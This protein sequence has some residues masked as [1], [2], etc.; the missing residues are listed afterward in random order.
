MPGELT[1]AYRAPAGGL[2]F[3]KLPKSGKC[4][5]NGKIKAHEAIP[6]YENT[7]TVPD[8]ADPPGDPIPPYAYPYPHPTPSCAPDAD[9][10]GE[11]G[12][13]LCG[14][15]GGPPLVNTYAATEDT[16][17]LSVCRK[18]GWKGVEAYKV[19]HGR[20]AYDV[21]GLRSAD[22]FVIVDDVISWLC[23]G[24]F[25]AQETKYLTATVSCTLNRPLED[26]IITGSGSI[27]VNRDSGIVTR[28][29]SRTVPEGEYPWDDLVSAA[30]AWDTIFTWFQAEL[31]EAM[32]LLPPEDLTF[33]GGG[34]AGIWSWENGDGVYLEL[35]FAVATG[36]F[37]RR[38]WVFN[39][40]EGLKLVNREEYAVAG[41][42][43]VLSSERWTSLGLIHV[44]AEE[45]ELEC[46]LSNPYMASENMTEAI[47]LAAMWNLSDDAEHPWR[48]DSMLGLVP[49]VVRNEPGSIAP[50]WTVEM[51]EE[52]W[53]D[54]NTNTYDGQVMG[55]P[56]PA[57]YERHWASHMVNWRGC[58]PSGE[59][60]AWYWPSYGALSPGNLPTNATW[61]T[62]P[63]E[64]SE[65]AVGAWTYGDNGGTRI[66]KHFECL[67][68]RPSINFFRPCGEDRVSWDETTV[69]CVTAEVGEDPA[70][71]TMEDTSSLATGDVCMHCG[72][73]TNGIFEITV[74]SGTEVELTTLVALLPS[75]FVCRTVLIEGDGSWFGRL[76]WPD[77]WPICGRVGIL[78][79]TQDGGEVVLVFTSA[80][81]HLWDGDEIDVSGVSGLST[82]LAVTMDDASTARIAGTLSGAYTSGGFA[83]STGAPD[84][85]W[86]DDQPKGDFVTVEWTL[87]PRPWQERAARNVREGEAVG[88]G[89]SCNGTDDEIRETAAAN[90]L[91]RS[92]SVL[93]ATQR[94]QRHQP[95]GPSVVGWT[96]NG[97]TFPNG[98]VTAMPTGPAADSTYGGYRWQAQVIQHLPDPLW[99]APAQGCNVLG[100]IPWQEDDGDCLSGTYPLR[101]WVEARCELPSGA[102]AL[103]DGMSLH[104]LTV[105]ELDGGYPPDGSVL[106]PPGATGHEDDGTPTDVPTPWGILFKEEGC[107]CTS[108][109]FS[110]DYA[111]QGVSCPE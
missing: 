24:E 96:P 11:V 95:C 28:S 30:G 74:L 46:V 55:A 39:E 10:C 98:L 83:K 36:L 48:T 29:L 27:N 19:W 42:S 71:L 14:P 40:I 22:S 16:V 15:T 2:A 109:L 37:E 60:F 99:Q 25:G 45:V 87:E 31:I 100:E 6:V 32:G 64:A 17:D 62:N 86:H 49:L 50:Y 94:G 76:R 3:A 5:G 41:T 52:D 38:D 66:K 103:P 102:P 110:A 111:A 21:Q 12:E 77:A 67:V 47:A 7:T 23:I 91:D 84:Y 78:S 4:T 58:I 69:Q 9:D 44:L 43:Y 33:T 82:G 105:A 68:T 54:S 20:L 73:T 108:G 61:W 51:A 26:V 88:E 63:R 1:S 34:T 70:V 75:G 107:V 90:G 89:Y 56:N 59:E 106:Y 97:E 80:Q 93:T 8:W 35:Q 79:A 53:E 85:F 92:V 104:I 57:G 13:K 72:G 18:L 65:H 101:P 81:P